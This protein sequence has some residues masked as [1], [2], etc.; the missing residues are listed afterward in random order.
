MFFAMV[1]DGVLV[2]FDEKHYMHREIRQ[3]ALD[4]VYQLFK[5][6]GMIQTGDFRD[7]LGISRKCA[8]IL[9]EG[10]DRERIT[11]ME[12]GGRVLK[13]NLQQADRSQ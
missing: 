11:A 1:R 3:K 2:R 5:E 13:R 7:R 8:I 9:L 4:M 12:N 10:F 6:K